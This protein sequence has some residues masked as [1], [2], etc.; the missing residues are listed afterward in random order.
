[1]NIK[2]IINKKR[3]KK[4]LTEDEMKFFIFS[5]FKDE[6]LEEQAAALLTLIYTNGI[7]KKEMAY[8]T[9][10]M[11]ETGTEIELYKISNKII[12]FHPIGGIEDKIIIVLLCI[13]ASFNIPIAKIAGR[14]L[15]LEDRLCAIPNYKTDISYE[16]FNKL[17]KNTNIGIM[18]KPINIA[19]VE[20]KLYRLRNSISCN[21]N[22]SLIT[23]SIM[24]QKIAIGARS[25]VFDITC[26]HNAY[27]KT[28][29]DAKKMASY[30]VD[31][32]K[33]INRNISCV[34]S[35]MEEPIG[36]SFGNLLEIKEVINILQGKM[37]KDVEDTIC[38]IGSRML[39]ILKVITNEKEGRNLILHSIQ[40]RRAYGCFV[41][42]LEYQGIDIEHIK[43]REDAEWIV[44]V[45]SNIE[46]YVKE[47]DV[48]L[49]RKT[50]IY[51]NAIKRKKEDK[52]DIG[53][54]IKLCKKIGD[55]VKIGEIIAYV[56]TND[57][58]KIRNAII[59]IADA[60]KF[61]EKRVSRKSRILGIIE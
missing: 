55:N 8:L 29:A 59:N 6:I 2:D 22:I 11:A 23:M 27:V 43:N 31:I 47:I 36:E 30:F 42:F 24:S 17:I 3:E 45:V 16:N 48:S 54:G 21:D 44:P 18:S 14:E 51:L 60:Y 28:Y 20:E 26:G 57:E 9:K 33:N 58:T 53:A 13:I 61:T 49:I 35:S 32:G 52:L 41:K 46:G 25:I 12:D 1:M 39:K 56:H 7:S 19:P 34:I 5:Y 38:K 4:E 15:G 40:R 37:T 10:A 50:G